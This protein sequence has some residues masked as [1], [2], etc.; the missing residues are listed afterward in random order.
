[1]TVISCSLAAHTS[2][3]MPF[4]GS[5]GPVVHLHAQEKPF[6]KADLAIYTHVLDVPGPGQC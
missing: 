5:T 3:L 1:M 4:T 2:L 6:V